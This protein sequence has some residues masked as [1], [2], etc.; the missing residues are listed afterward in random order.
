MI[1]FTERWTKPSM[2]CA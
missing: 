2:A 1:I